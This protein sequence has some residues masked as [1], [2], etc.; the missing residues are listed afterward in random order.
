VQGERCFLHLLEHVPAGLAV[1]D[2]RYRLTAYHVRWLGG[3]E[4]MMSTS[5][6]AELE[7]MLAS[8]LENLGSML[9]LPLE[10]HGARCVE[11]EYDVRLGKN[12]RSDK[13][14]KAAPN[15]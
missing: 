12:P 4:Y 10:H 8:E 15:T 13:A 14:E 9:L 11:D 2:L 6:G 5:L 3:I 7:V 1:P